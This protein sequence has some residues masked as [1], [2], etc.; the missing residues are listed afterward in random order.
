ML[1]FNDIT[2]HNVLWDFCF[3]INRV[4][5]RGVLVNIVTS[6]INSWEKL[7]LNIYV[8]IFIYTRWYNLTNSLV[9]WWKYSVSNHENNNSIS[10]LFLHFSVFFQELFLSFSFRSF[11]FFP[12]FIS[13]A[14]KSYPYL[15][16][17]RHFCRQKCMGDFLVIDGKKQRLLFLS[18]IY[19][20]F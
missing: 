10:T 18:F 20:Y 14:T 17:Y 19:I 8:F 13:S 7:I 15:F 12:P 16:P 6:E 4:I 1:L 2:V 3:L 5:K 11:F 9:A